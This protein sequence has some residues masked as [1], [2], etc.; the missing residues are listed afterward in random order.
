MPAIINLSPA[1]ERGSQYR[2]PIFTPANAVDHK[3]QA[4]I[5]RKIVE[6]CNGLFNGNPFVT[7]PVKRNFGSILI[8]G[9][10][11]Q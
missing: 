2:K 9:I 8:E 4:S 10:Y 1:K 6:D 3:K 11:G 5:A 7:I